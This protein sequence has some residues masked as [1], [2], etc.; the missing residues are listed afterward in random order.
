[1]SD[2]SSLPL[3][4]SG[5]WTGTAPDA[6]AMFA[7]A[8]VALDTMP[9]VFLPHIQGV[10]IAIEEFADDEVLKS[11]DIEH[12]YDLTGLY[13]GRP[14]TERSIDQSG[15]MPDRVT[16]YRI[17]ILV[18][19]IETGERL[20]RLVRHVLIHEIGHHFGF[21]DDDMHALEDMA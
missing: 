17:P 10:V 21:S 1:M 15:G 9:A 19:W 7:M 18:E 3:N 14:L 11:L 16:L 4:A 12:P 8:E 6:D 20:D 13:E 5:V 2:K